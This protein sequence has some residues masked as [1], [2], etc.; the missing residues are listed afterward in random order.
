MALM[1]LMTEECVCLE[2]QGSSKQAVLAELVDMLD[3]AGKLADREAF[4]QAIIDREA[5]GST[6]FQH[7]VAV[8]HARSDSVRQP[9]IA[10]GIAREGIEF[11]ALDGQPSQ[12]FLMIAEPSEVDSRHLDVLA[13]ASC[14]L[15][16]P[17]FRQRLLAAGSPA[18]VMELFAAAEGG[19]PLPEI[20]VPAGRMVAAV[21]SCPAGISHTYMAA[22]RLRESARRMGISIKV[23]T[24]GAV[25]VRDR[26]T[27]EDIEKADAVILAVDRTINKDRFAGKRAVEVWVTDAIRHA[28][29]LLTRA[30]QPEADVEPEPTG[31][32][33][34]RMLA[35][36]GAELY[37]HLMNGISNVL[38]FVVAGGILMSLARLFGFGAAVTN[39]PE[40]HPLA[41]LLMQF[42]GVQGAFGLLTPVLAGFVGRSVAD[43]PGFMPA[44][45]GGF[46]MAQAGAGLLGGMIAGLVAGYG[47]MAIDILCRRWPSQIDAT[48]AIVV[49]PLAG[50]LL[51]GV[52]V[53]LA[54][55]PMVAVNQG[56][57][58]WLAG[59]ELWQRVALGA[60]LGGMM[61]FDMG[62]PVNKAAFTFG[63]VAIGT[64]NYLPPAAVMAAGMV[65]P[66]ALGVAAVIAGDRFNEVE[67]QS[68][69]RSVL[70]GATFVT[71]A[72]IPY[73]AS[74]PKRVIPCCMVGAA[75]A[76]ALSMAFGCELLVPHGG[77][78]V[79]PLVGHWHLYIAAILAGTLITACLVVGLKPKQAG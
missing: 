66:L 74:D 18:Q 37:R 57:T 79:I 52:L 5:T 77:V 23:E 3:R 56:L 25:G 70:M 7:G 17:D 27:S 11:D 67:R 8:P 31:H 42:G 4:L 58:S 29:E 68:G 12:F 38:P 22:E 21:T 13:A 44:M 47:V 9:A 2:L 75:T 50:L 10:F 41:S 39:S 72:A 16:E 48:K 69:K 14:H 55:G 40:Q 19:D 78:F 53:L 1:S 60:F 28:D 71:E 15:I 73:A 26:L 61:A 32:A 63:I 54:I 20:Q 24:H 30:L 45:V 76:G 59:L 6:G 43:R 46:V 35:F 62:G 36:Q 64:A 34:A 33:Y 65:P 51:T 49:Y